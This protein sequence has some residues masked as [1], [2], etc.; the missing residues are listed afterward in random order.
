MTATKHQRSD[1]LIMRTGES[2]ISSIREL[3]KLLECSDKQEQSRVAEPT[4]AV[5]ERAILKSFTFPTIEHR[6]DT[7]SEAHEKTFQWIFRSPE[8]HDKPWSDFTHW[9]QFED[10][11]YWISGKAAS[12]KSTL[13][14]YFRGHPLI[15]KHLAA[16]SGKTPLTV[17]HFF[18][19][20]AGTP[21][22]KS[23]AG[24][25]RTLIHQVL[26][27]RRELIPHV[28]PE[29]WQEAKSYTVNTLERLHKSWHAWSVSDLKQLLEDLIRQTEFSS[30]FCFFVDGLDEYDGDHTEITSLV[31]RISSYANV[32][33][34]LASRPLMVFENEFE[35]YPT[36]RLQDLTVDDIRL[37]IDDKLNQHR[38]VKELKE[39][40]PD[41]MQDLITE[42]VQ[43]SSGVFLW[44]AIVTSDLLKGL[45]NQDSLS[46]LQNVLRKLPPEL[47]DL[48]F[49]MFTSIKPRLYMEQAS[50]LFQIV[51]HKE[52]PLS[53]IEL[54]FADDENPNLALSACIEEL[55]PEE[56]RARERA[57]SARIKSRCA[58]LLEVRAMQSR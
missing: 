21:L 5:I 35:G 57:I 13:M 42:I 45:T 15:A 33:L 17:A 30:K 52:S 56:K 40:D 24:L 49:H 12:G 36:L 6:Q 46:D 51:Y 39:Q 48:F 47:D 32:K 3:A 44:V 28:M 34:C 22:Q 16:W 54:S 7:I 38:K 14:K 27:E 58:G 19:W 4:P 10:D 37:F 25:L 23:Q 8:L 2:I 18:F 29:L 53:A 43:M 31:S 26:D 11:I 41:K 1:E 55:S 9:L 20:Y 50:R